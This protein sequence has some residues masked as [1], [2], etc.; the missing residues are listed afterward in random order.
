M[1]HTGEESNRG[2][3][4]GVKWC[5]LNNFVRLKIQDVKLLSYRSLRRKKFKGVTLK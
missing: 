3:T 4:R 2:M 5:W 1:G